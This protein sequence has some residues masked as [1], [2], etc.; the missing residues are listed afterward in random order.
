MNTNT[1][2]DFHTQYQQQR[3]NEQPDELKPLFDIVQLPSK[4]MFYPNGTPSEVEVYYLTTKDEDTL[5]TPG[6]LETGK[7]YDVLVKRKLKDKSINPDTLLKGDIDAILLFLRTSGYGEDY[8]VIVTDPDNGD[9][10]E[11]KIDL[12]KLKFKEVKH[13][14]DEMMQFNFLLPLR[15]KN[16]KVRLLN[17]MEEDTLNRNIENQKKLSNDQIVHSVSMRLKAH[18][19]SIEGN[20]SRGYIDSFVDNMP[21]KDSLHLRKFLNEIEPGIDTSYEFTSPKGNTFTSGFRFG[22]DFFFPSI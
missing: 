17:S 4:G 5:T 7:V 11:S 15:K 3:V 18:I 16:I 12:T 21:P 10:F 2:V 9:E 19:H 13:T 20:T 8:P 6:L 22:L 14:P 1:N